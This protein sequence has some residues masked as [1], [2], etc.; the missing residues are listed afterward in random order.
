MSE[1]YSRTI[2]KQAIA[3]ASLALGFKNANPDVLENINLIKV[4]NI[5][6]VLEIC[7]EHN[8]LKFNQF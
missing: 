2:S 3:R 6:Q 8:D 7:L 5:L 4:K 1:E